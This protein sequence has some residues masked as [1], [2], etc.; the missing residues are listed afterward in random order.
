[1]AYISSRQIAL[2]QVIISLFFFHFAN[3]QE[4]KSIFYEKGFQLGYGYGINGLSLPEGNYQ[5]IYLQGRFSIDLTKNK[6]P[7]HKV[8]GKA[9]FYFE[10]QFNPVLIVGKD[11]TVQNLEFGLNFGFQQNF[12]IT[13]KL[14][15]FILASLGPHYF[16]TETT[17]Q[18]RGFIFSDC[19]GI[20]MYYF[21]N[22]KVAINLNY[23]IRHMSNADTV[24][25]NFGVNTNNYHIGISWFMSK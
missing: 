24:M 21:M 1:M 3:A 13:P 12:V 19:M 11:S 4:K 10:P 14:H 15:L 22:K 9:F 25:P 16:T 5:V 8:I 23:R 7:I 18:N 20:G 2:F 6:T 17:R